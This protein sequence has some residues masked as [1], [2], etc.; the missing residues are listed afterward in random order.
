[1][2]CAMS[3]I[4]AAG[5]AVLTLACAAAADAQRSVATTVYESV[6]PAVVFVETDGGS[7]SGLLLESNTILTAAHVVYPNRSARIVFPHGTELREVP[8]IGWDLIADV[9]VLGPV[10]LEARPALPPFDTT[11]GLPIGADLFVIGYPGEEESFPQPTISR[12]ILSRYRRWPDQE[13]TYLQTDAS[14]GGGQSGGVVASAAGAVVGMTVF[15]GHFGH[16]G[17]ALSAADV[18]PRAAAL[19]A[20]EDPAELGDRGWD[21]DP[22]ATPLRFDLETFWSVQAFVIDAEPDEEVTFSVRSGGDVLVEIVDGTGYS[23]AET[24]DNESG[25]ESITATLDGVAPF[26]LL[27]EQFSDE[28]ARVGIEGEVALTPLSDPDD[29][30]TLEVPARRAGAIDYPYDVD[31]YL[32]PLA[33]GETVRVRVD[34]TQID[35]FLRIDYRDSAAVTEDDDSGG[36]LFGLNAE[37]VYQA[38]DDRVHRIV[39]NDQ[40]GEVGGYTLTIEPENSRPGEP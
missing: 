40:F 39:I 33:A 28:K 36:G 5:V 8:L 2:I 1:M 31:F 7:G 19:L 21:G 3:R 30:V 38:E 4:V 18:L 13:A 20:G 16:F 15:G 26:L 27:V 29:A 10:Q 32:L 24:D 34:S 17:M 25:T 35:P 14:L 23:L 12:G 11:D 22:Q 6:A 9:A 37:L